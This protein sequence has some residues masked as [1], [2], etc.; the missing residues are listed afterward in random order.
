MEEILIGVALAAAAGGGADVLRVAGRRL[1]APV[2]TL[3]LGVVTAVLS[4]AGNL[5]LG[6]LAAFDRDS[7]ALAGGQWWRII[8]PLVVQD[9]GWPGTVFNL[10]ALLGV[11][12]VAEALYGRRV[13]VG[14]YLLAGLVSEI[15]AYTILPHQGFAGNSVAD[16]GLAALCLVAS[17][18]RPRTLAQAFGVIGLAAGAALIGT[19]NLHGVGF[20]VGAICGVLLIVRERRQPS[21]T[22][23]RPPAGSRPPRRNRSGHLPPR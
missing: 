9:G 8:T 21:T 19:A 15:A 4:A 14:V 20:T 12:T 18:A 2:A 6:M 22:G 7:R 1:V 10:V 17:A 23:G 13:L 16:L 3:V 5:D 11:G